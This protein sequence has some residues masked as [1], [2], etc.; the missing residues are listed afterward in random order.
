MNARNLHL[1]LP[2]NRKKKYS[3]INT[4]YCTPRTNTA[5]TYVLRQERGVFNSENN[6]QILH[7][8]HLSLSLSLNDSPKWRL[9]VTGFILFLRDS[10]F[11]SCSCGCEFAHFPTKPRYKARSLIAR[12]VC[13]GGAKT[14]NCNNLSA[15][16]FETVTR[17]AWY[18][19]NYSFYGSK[20]SEAT[21]R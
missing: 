10:L 21:R 19:L 1:V 15:P 9:V 3:I 16:V 7:M 12:T 6:Q 14:G 18:S 4:F 17:V 8:S 13:G 2:Y 11:T 20:F 5:C